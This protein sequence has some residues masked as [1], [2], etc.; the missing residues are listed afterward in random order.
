MKI[1]IKGYQA[2][3]E[4]FRAVMTDSDV[5]C[6]IEAALMH[7]LVDE[8]HVD[9]WFIGR[10]FQI[11]A[12]EAPAT[13]SLLDTRTAAIKR[14]Q[15]SLRAGDSAW[16]P[17]FADVFMDGQRIGQVVSDGF[18]H[19]KWS[20]QPASDARRPIV[21]KCFDHVLPAWAAGATYGPFRTYDE[22]TRRVP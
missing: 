3:T 4:S 7:A 18:T 9:D 2:H 19:S 11:A 5:A 13:P 1:T 6:T 15:E 20:F 17:V 22:L 16:Q 12:I 21:D 14:A 10:T 8:L